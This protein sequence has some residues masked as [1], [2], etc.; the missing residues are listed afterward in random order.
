[1]LKKGWNKYYEKNKEKIMESRKKYYEKNKEMITTKANKN[2]QQKNSAQKGNVRKNL[3]GKHECYD[4]IVS[5]GGY[6]DLNGCEP[7]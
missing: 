7:S 6:L 5:D 4:V 2:Y 3:E 1:M